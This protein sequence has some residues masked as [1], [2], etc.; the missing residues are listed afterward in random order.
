MIEAALLCLAQA[1]YYEARSEPV[2][3]QYAVAGVV[4]NRVDDPRYED[5]VCEVVAEDW[6]PERWD[7]QFSYMC[8]GK[9]E[10]M[11]DPEARDL[12]MLIAKLMLVHEQKLDIVGDAVFYHT[13]DIKPDWAKELPVIAVIGNHIF[14][15]ED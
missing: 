12:A 10:I 4:L 14:Y 15:G 6:G 13:T 8:D 9:P 11:A 7:C 2:L 5:T 1:I 3:G